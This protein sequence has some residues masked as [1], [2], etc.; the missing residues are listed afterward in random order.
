MIYL[1]VCT[2]SDTSLF[3]DCIIMLISVDEFA[4]PSLVVAKDRII[5]DRSTIYRWCPPTSS[6]SQ[7]HPTSII[8]D[9]HCP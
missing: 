4:L 8:V 5:V 1:I 7:L 3:L 9:L 2:Y 6:I